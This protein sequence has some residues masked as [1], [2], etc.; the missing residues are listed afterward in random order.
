MATHHT[1]KNLYNLF[2]YSGLDQR[3]YHAIETRL[4]ERNH[5]SLRDVCF[6]TMI[7]GFI[8]LILILFKVMPQRML[9]PY[10]YLTVISLVFFLVFNLPFTKSI[11]TGKIFLY[12]YLYLLFFFTTLL[13]TKYSLYSTFAVFFNVMIVFLPTL[14]IESPSRAIVIIIS[15]VIIFDLM[16]LHYK[17]GIVLVSDLTNSLIFGLLAIYCNFRITSMIVKQFAYERKIE[18]EKNY[19]GLTKIMNKEYSEKMI[20]DA[21]EHH[22]PGCLLIIDIDHFKQ[23]NDNYGHSYG[24]EV[25]YKVAQGLKEIFRD[26]DIIGRFGGDEMIVFM[27]RANVDNAKAKAEDYRERLKVVFKDKS[28]VTYSIGIASS[29]ETFQYETLLN[30][31]DDALYFAKDHGRDQVVIFKG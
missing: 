20:K 28:P 12:I 7:L 4:Y 30:N 8:F 25:L 17:T 16:V 11:K 18:K 22:I 27:Y 21:L 26:E 14:F 6:F 24:D 3:T 23:F 10:C 5:K 13:G 29:D 19:D 31:A 15:N 9:V 2:F 1:Q